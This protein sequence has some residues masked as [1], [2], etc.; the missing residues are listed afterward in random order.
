MC[1]HDVILELRIFRISYESYVM[2]HIWWVIPIR[3]VHI[4][5]ASSEFIFVDPGNKSDHATPTN[6]DKW[7]L[8][9]RVINCDLMIISVRTFNG[10][11]WIIIISIFQNFDRRIFDR[12]LSYPYPNQEYE[13]E[14]DLNLELQVDDVPYW[15][16]GDI[17]YSDFISI[18]IHYS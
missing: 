14:E 9:I 12:K 3:I 6:I 2:S 15:L 1:F 8:L 17:F 10:V 16:T 13:H 18:S 5:G 4:D 7:N 11:S